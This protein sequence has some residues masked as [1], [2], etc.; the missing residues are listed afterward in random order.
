MFAY[1]LAQDVSV[2]AVLAAHVARI[3]GMINMARLNVLENVTSKWQPDHLLQNV[4]DLT[5]LL[6]HFL[7]L[8]TSE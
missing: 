8:R 5:I 4:E 1:V 2:L 3:A 7:K 6:S